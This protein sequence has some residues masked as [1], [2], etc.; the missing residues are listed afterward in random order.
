MTTRKTAVDFEIDGQRIAPGTRRQVSL[1][2]GSLYTSAP[3]TLPVY[4]VHGRRKG[5]V[6]FVSA[7]LHGDEINGIEIV[8]RVLEL[9]ALRQLRGTLLAVPV[10]NVLGF[11]HRSRYLPDR[12]DLNR[13]FPGSE[14]GSLAARLANRFLTEVVDR[15]DAGI[16]LH[17]GALQR[18]NLPQIRADLRNEETHRLANAFGAPVMLDSPPVDGT[19]RAHVT[20]QGMPVLLYE[21]GEA[22]RFNEVAIRLGVRG[23]MNV[24][25]ALGMLRALSRHAPPIQ[26]VTAHSSSWVRA[27]ISGVLRAQTELGQAVKEGDR[28]GWVGDPVGGTDTAVYAHT[29]GIIIGRTSLP[30]VYEGDAMFHIARIEDAHEAAEMVAVARKLA[31]AM[32]RPRARFD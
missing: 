27:P 19:L 17:T 24:L 1:Q 10:L 32:P 2:I 3:V 26:P 12:R 14:G 6:L 21:A 16:D 22:L 23:V 4:V 28:V 25:R 30:L 29:G 13:S 18:P 20:S 11:L 5:P 8:R 9:P 7:A 15:A 31:A